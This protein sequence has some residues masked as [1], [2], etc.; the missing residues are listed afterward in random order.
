V[1]DEY[2]LFHRN[3]ALFRFVECCCLDNVT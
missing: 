1:T 2:F 3:T